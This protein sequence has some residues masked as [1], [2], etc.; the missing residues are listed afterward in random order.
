MCIRDRLKAGPVTGTTQ[1]TEIAKRFRAP[2][3]TKDMGLIDW[4]K[5]AD[6]IVRHV[7]A[8]QPWPTAYTYLHRPGKEPIRAMLSLVRTHETVS[9]DT[10]GSAKVVG[11]ELHVTAGASSVVHVIELQPAGKKKMPAAEFLRGHAL[12]DGSRFGPERLS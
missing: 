6:E 2:K 10:P 11:N 9:E 5:P 1:D 8:M 12:A 7:R 4:S 3:L